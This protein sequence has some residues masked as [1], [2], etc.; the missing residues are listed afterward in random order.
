M[1]TDILQARGRETASVRLIGTWKGTLPVTIRHRQSIPLP[2]RD[3]RESQQSEVGEGEVPF[4]LLLA[5]K[6]MHGVK[7]EIIEEVHEV[8]T[9]A[10]EGKIEAS[11]EAMSMAGSGAQNTAI[12]FVCRV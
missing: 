9:W 5:M 2:M 3:L 12:S 11:K 8:V 7:L 4:G 6:L 1:G 10:F